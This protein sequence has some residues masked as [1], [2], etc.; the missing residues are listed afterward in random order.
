MILHKT[1]Q[2]FIVAAIV[3]LLFSGQPAHAITAMPLWISIDIL[4]LP[5]DNLTFLQGVI[6]RMSLVFDRAQ[7][8]YRSHYA[9]YRIEKASDVVDEDALRYI[10]AH[11]DY[12]LGVTKLPPSFD[13]SVCE[14]PRHSLE[15][16]QDWSADPMLHLLP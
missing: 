1:F 12:L 3:G 10:Y 13:L 8:E 4:S 14:I 6:F 2:K 15:T 9:D 16:L 7:Q 11:R 5:S